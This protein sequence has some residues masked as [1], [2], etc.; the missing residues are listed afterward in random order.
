M[1]HTNQSL[2]KISKSSYIARTSST[3]PFGYALSEIKGRL[4][5]LP[6]E[7]KVLYVAQ[8]WV[9]T[10]ASFGNAVSF[11]EE[12]TGRK[13]SRCGLYKNFSK[14]KFIPNLYNIDIKKLKRNC[15][16]C[17]KIYFISPIKKEETEHL[18]YCT[19][20]YCTN[21]CYKKSKRKFPVTKKL[22][23]CGNKINSSEG[24]L[25][26]MT[27][28]Y[29]KG[30]VKVGRTYDTKKRL[31]AFNTSTPYKNFKLEYERK[32]QDYILSEFLLLQKLDN[33]CEKK[34]GE[35]FKIKVSKTI[36]IIN[37]LPDY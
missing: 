15:K 6:K 18:K 24:F 37:A 25:Y 11:M 5:P 2:I 16:I 7:L 12:N 13:L 22:L 31:S 20:K 35:W 30:W 14:N 26:C 27:N 33:I 1:K 3:I 19:D 17:D 23:T 32:F 28:S 8:E 10:G 9:K 21:K 4:K 36:K 34:K 29:Y